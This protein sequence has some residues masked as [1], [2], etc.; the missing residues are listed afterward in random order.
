[1][2]VYVLGTCK[3][4][5]NSD[6]VASN[7]G[8]F[9]ARY[10]LC[11]STLSYTE[12]K[13]HIYLLVVKWVKIV[14]CIEN[15]WQTLICQKLVK[16]VPKTSYFMTNFSLSLVCHFLTRQRNWQIFDKLIPKICHFWNPFL[17][18][19]LTN[20]LHFHRFSCHKFIT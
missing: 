4:V 9:M 12:W 20:Q 6:K 1:M 10:F 13:L 19:F 2:N 7:D 11:R 18:T 5:Y 3:I 15:A 16:M 17:D 14:T 8:K